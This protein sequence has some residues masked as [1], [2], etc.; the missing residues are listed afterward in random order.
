MTV[1]AI[2]AAVNNSRA[3]RDAEAYAFKPAPPPTVLDAA[4]LLR[5]EMKPARAVVPGWLYEGLGLLAAAPKVGKSTL[6]LQIVVAVAKGGEFWGEAVP[7]AR[8]LMIDLETNERRLRRK[9]DDAGVSDLEPG[10]LMYATSWPRGRAG[11]ERIAE[12]VDAHQVKLVV[13]DTWQRFR[14]T[15]SG[16]RNAYASDYDALAMVQE[17]CKSRPGL[18]IVA[19]HH[20][21]KAVSD[22]PI[23]SIN[24]SAG[25]AASA[26]AVW[27]MTRK[28]AE[29][30]LHIEARDWE[31]DDNEFRIER[32]NGRWS[33][34]DAPRFSQNDAEVLRLLDIG[35]GMT[36][37][38]LGEGLGISKQAAHARLHR[39]R[40]AGLVRCDKGVWNA[41]V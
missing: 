10:M 35:K 32:D 2:K 1:G 19:V 14:E 41:A 17:L 3:M 37:T 29:F 5:K 6:M 20:R 13:I 34:S 8:V 36:P 39:M 23:D 33:L 4:D 12:Y 27:I 18:A 22:D 31:R 38:A 30:A 7:K 15:D 24:G 21:R 25:L 16:K 28:G 26:D 9:L 40:D 11:V